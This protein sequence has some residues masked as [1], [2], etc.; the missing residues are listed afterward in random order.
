MMKLSIVVPVYNMEKYLADCLQSLLNPELR[1]YEVIVVNDG[2]TDRSAEIIYDWHRRFPALLRPVD[3]P[4]G[5]LGHARNVGLSLA[6]GKYVLFVDSDDTLVP[7]ALEEILA[8]A[9]QN[10]DIV[11]FDF[12]HVD[13]DGRELAQYSGCE[14]SGEFSLSDYPA[15]LLSP[16]NACNKLWRRELFTKNG[17]AFPNRLWFE[18]LATSP[19][20]ILHAEKILPVHK[21]W[22]RY[23][24]RRGSITNATKADRNSEMITVVQSV[25]DYYEEAKA[26]ERYAPE[27]EYLCFYHEFLTS[28]TRV[29]LIDPK[30]LVQDALREDYLRRFPKYR[31]NPYFRS[32]PGKYRL[33]ADLIEHR[34][35]RCVHLLMAMN[36]KV[37]GRG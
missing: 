7:G 10:F 9:D 27:L 5:G 14:G 36:N 31:S 16:M 37:K 6:G 28:V 21:T 33:L 11:V 34:H 12:V 1:D 29:N 8:L 20:L 24:Q 4:N 32:A 17:I 3:T 25:L 15:F 26:A 2:S 19:K 13:E 35:W 30:S 22:Y 18:D 23:L